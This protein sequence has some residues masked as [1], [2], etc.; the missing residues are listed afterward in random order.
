MKCTRSP[1]YHSTHSNSH[2]LQ[3]AIIDAAFVLLSN[4]RDFEEQDVHHLQSTHLS[5]DG[6]RTGASMRY[7][8]TFGG[9]WSQDRQTA[10]CSYL[11]SRTPCWGGPSRSPQIIALSNLRILHFIR[12]HPFASGHPTHAAGQPQQLHTGRPDEHLMTSEIGYR[13]SDQAL[14]S[15]NPQNTS[16]QPSWSP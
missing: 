2:A 16:T 11:L 15:Y 4:M 8:M 1:H 5:P 9:Q 14:T 10:Q 3:P 7:F 6:A 12:R 13:Q